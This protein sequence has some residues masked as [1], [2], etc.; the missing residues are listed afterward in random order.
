MARTGQNI[1]KR[2]DGRWEARYMKGRDEAGKAKYGYLYARSY[3]EVRQKLLFKLT[4]LP[5]KE[6]AERKAEKECYSFW[7]N[8]WLQS[9]KLRVKASSY[10]KYRNLAYNHI[11]P[12]LGNVSVDQLT[13]SLIEK[14][15]AQFLCAGRK[16]KKGGLSPETVANILYMIKDSLRYAQAEGAIHSCSFH[17]ISVKKSPSEMRVLSNEEEERLLRILLHEMDRYKLGIFLCLYTGIRVG[18]LCALKWKD[19]SLFEKTLT[20]KGTMQRLQ[21]DA[22]IGTQKTRVVITEPK[23]S[24]ALRTI[25]LP[26][27]VVERLLE[28]QCQANDF[29]LTGSEKYYIEPRT[30]QNR[31]KAYLKQG[32]IADANFHSLRHTFA[33][34]CIE[35]GFDVKSLSEILGHSS[36]KLT[37]DKYVHSSME[38]KRSNMEKLRIL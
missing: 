12:C 16:D 31:F 32:K 27:F 28:F 13:T 8:E 20:I 14:S 21:H 23:S 33:T 26:M 11:I 9:T 25:P 17:R 29:L 34:R 6:E 3:K 35:S 37:L 10:I 18:E 1:Y 4:E 2:K 24:Y 5:E 19:I 36:V 15:I 30:M 38:L 22:V 7:L